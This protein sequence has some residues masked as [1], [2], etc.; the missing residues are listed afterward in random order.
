MTGREQRNKKEIEP[1]HRKRGNRKH[2]QLVGNTTKKVERE[3]RRHENKE[4]N[5]KK[6]E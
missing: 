1:L 5:W 6:E 4:P 2:E 3:I